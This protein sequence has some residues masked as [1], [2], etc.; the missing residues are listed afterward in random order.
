MR[1]LTRWFASS[2]QT[3][4][5]DSTLAAGE[6]VPVHLV[7]QV[8]DDQLG[9]LTGLALDGLHLDD[10]THPDRPA[11]GA[12]GLLDAFSPDDERA[13]RE[14]RAV[15]PLETGGEGLLLRGLGVLQDPVHR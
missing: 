9:A 3:T 1:L 2:K 6:P 13:G 7:G 8:G 15:H 10:R 11:A 4:T 5:P 14:V 12:I